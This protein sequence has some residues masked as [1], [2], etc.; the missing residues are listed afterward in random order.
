M[1]ISVSIIDSLSCIPETSATLQS[2]YAPI[3]IKKR[4][5]QTYFP[6]WLSP[7][8]FYQ[9][10]L[11]DAFSLPYCQHFVLLQ[12]FKILTIVTFVIISFCGFVFP[13]LLMTLNFSCAYLPSVY[14]RQWNVS[15]CSAYILLGL[16]PFLNCW[17]LRIFM[18]SPYSALSNMWLANIFSHSIAY[19]LASSF[20]EQKFW[21]SMKS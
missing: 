5:C 14:A 16:F 18:C 8:R 12:V 20:A 9:Q 1:D 15:S 3:K 6:E 7:F 4:N 21:I 10:C 13:E 17:V 19:F 11:S 2:N